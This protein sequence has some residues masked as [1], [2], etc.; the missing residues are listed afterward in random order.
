MRDQ[1][2]IVGLGATPYYRRGA[3][4][5]QTLEEL[6]GK[7]ILGAVDDA[8]LRVRENDGRAKESKTFAKHRQFD[9]MKNSHALSRPARCF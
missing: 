4:V 6:V 1:T 2:A 9:S 3:S 7:A 5:P 8:G